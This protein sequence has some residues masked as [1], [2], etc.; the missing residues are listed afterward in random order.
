M[1]TA[2]LKLA[3]RGDRNISILLLLL[4]SLLHA[5]ESLLHASESDL[6]F[7]QLVSAQEVRK[8]IEV[9]HYQPLVVLI[10]FCNIC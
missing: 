6:F 9:Y 4:L 7:L 3:K 2:P 1:F 5:S 8:R 10:N